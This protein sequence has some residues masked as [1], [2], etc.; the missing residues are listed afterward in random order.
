MVSQYAM[1][2]AKSKDIKKEAIGYKIRNRKVIAAD[3]DFEKVC[4]K[5][6]RETLILDETSEDQLGTGSPI[7]EMPEKIIQIVTEENEL[8]TNSLLD[9]IEIQGKKSSKETLKMAKKRRTS[10]ITKQS[11]QAK[12]LEQE[13]HDLSKQFQKQDEL[14]ERSYLKTYKGMNQTHDRDHQKAQ[15]IVHNL[16]YDPTNPEIAQNPIL[17]R[18]RE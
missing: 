17:N 12:R 6:F 18:K 9:N 7:F 8:D 11:H 4:K 5:K 14:K 16:V 10:S 3:L 15:S 1:R 2:K 13:Q